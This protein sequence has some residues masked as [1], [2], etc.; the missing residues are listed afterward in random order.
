MAQSIE[1]EAGV[2]HAASFLEPYVQSGSLNFLIGSGASFPAIKMAGSIEDEINKLLAANSEAEANLK[3]VSFVEAINLAHRKIL[4]TPDEADT[5]S[6]VHGYSRFT[7]LI[8]R[9]LFARKNLLLP[10]QANVFTTNYDMF[11]EHAASL[12]PGVILND[13]FDRSP[14]LMDASTFAPERFFDRT[15][16]SGPVYGHQTEIP[17]I[18]LVKI[19]GSIS[20]RKKATSILYSPS[21]ITD[22]TVDEKKDPSKVKAYLEKHFLILPN[23][24][25]FHTT[26]FER[27]YYDL[28][29]LFSKAMDQENAVLFAFGFSFA[30]EHILDVTRRALRN[31]TA[32][33]IVFAFD[34]PSVAGYEAKFSPHRNVSIISPKAGATIDFSR[35]NN[36]LEAIVSVQANAH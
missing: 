13:G 32:Q 15:Y 36:I 34:K 24:K 14:G 18:N 27:V 17:T 28:L 22:L 4:K 19:H 1:L 3:C 10:R 12:L 11:I 29:R 26:L 6:V 5:K 30:D 23:L 21:P 9:I 16:R 7:G 25:K 35:L 33:L 8:D 2:D 31:P 20:W